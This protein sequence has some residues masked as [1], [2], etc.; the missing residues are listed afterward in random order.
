MEAARLAA[1]GRAKC[2]A[3]GNGEPD[4]HDEFGTF[5]DDEDSDAEDYDFVTVH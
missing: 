4:D 3:G 5:T 1:A 2:A